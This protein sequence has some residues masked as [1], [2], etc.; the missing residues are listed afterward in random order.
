MVSR[1][2]D[3]DIGALK[4]ALEEA[5]KCWLDFKKCLG[6]FLRPETGASYWVETREF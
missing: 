2:R 3:N 6:Q 1:G 4:I 5:R